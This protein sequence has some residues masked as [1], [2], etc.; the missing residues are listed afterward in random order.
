MAQT[1]KNLAAMQE[2][3]VQSLGWEDPL[4]EGM[5]THS[6]ILAWRIPWTEE[7]DRLYSPWGCKELNMTATK[8]TYIPSES[9][10]SY[11]KKESVGVCTCVH[12]CM[13]VCVHKHIRN[14]LSSSLNFITTK[15]KLMLRSQLR[16][17]FFQDVYSATHPTRKLAFP[18][19]SALCLCVSVFGHVQLFCDPTDYRPP[20]SSVHEISQARILE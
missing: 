11:F 6:S 8:H 19:P 5:A 4:K 10:C 20:G 12:V 17:Y 3:W 2:T 14:P 13:C 9:L 18:P 7:P 16:F 1:V 15:K